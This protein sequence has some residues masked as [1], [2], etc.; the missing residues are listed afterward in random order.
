MNRKPL[1][2]Y[3]RFVNLPV[4]SHFGRY[5]QIRNHICEKNPDCSYNRYTGKH[6]V[7]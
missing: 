4:G 7:R 6:R 5:Y 3:G 2:F 1:S